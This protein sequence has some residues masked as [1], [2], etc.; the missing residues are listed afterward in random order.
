MRLL[1]QDLTRA[2]K[3]L[4]KD[5]TYYYVNPRNL[6][7]IK[8]VRVNLPE[9]PIVIKRWNPTKGGSEDAAKEE[10]M[11]QQMLWRYAH[12]LENKTPVNVDRAVGASYNTRSVLE[13]LLAQR[14]LLFSCILQLQHAKHLQKLLCVLCAK[15]SNLFVI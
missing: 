11:S 10:T 14:D 15:L 3:Q 5:K 2:I 8:I 12:H 4:P 1:A 13:A 6:G 7:K 9:G